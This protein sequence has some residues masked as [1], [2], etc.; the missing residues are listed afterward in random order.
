MHFESGQTSV[1]R[2]RQKV[3]SDEQKPDGQWQESTEAVEL[4]NFRY[5]E[6]LI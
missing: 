4:E 6:K 5:E 2:T 3:K 1:T